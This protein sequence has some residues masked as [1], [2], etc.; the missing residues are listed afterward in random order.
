MQNRI[1]LVS[2]ESDF[3][4]YIS[5]K[6]DLR[7]NDELYH[8]AYED[9]PEKL[10]LLSSSVL[11]L[12]SQNSEQK[13]LEL[14]KILKST[15]VIV[16]SF[17]EDVDFRAEC[18][19]QG[20]LG[21]ITLVTQENEFNSIIISAL[22]SLSFLKKTENYRE[23]LVEKNVLAQNNEVYYDYKNIIEKELEKIKSGASSAILAAI[24]PNDK[25]KFLLNSNQIETFV[26]SNIRKSDIL[27]N[28]AANKYFLLLNDT[29]FE[30]AQKIWQN[31]Q[32]NI[33]EKLYAGFASS[34]NLKTC[35]QWINEALNKLHEAIN[36]DYVSP[37][38]NSS[39]VSNFKLFRQEF[40]KRLEKII[41][42]VFY[43]IEQ[44]YSEKLFGIS[45]VHSVTDGFGELITKS[46]LLCGEFKITAPGLSKINIDITFRS[47][48]ENNDIQSYPQSKRITIEPEE[49][50]PSLLEDLLEQFI[51]EFKD[52]VENEHIKRK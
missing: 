11:I 47:N 8:F 35:S 49:L 1:V 46:K 15:P 16:F 33:P 5:P 40:N 50:E 13:T 34:T 23:I 43:H 27:M 14:L 20:A 44:K 6:L 45:V 29:N 17:N 18:Y 4:E 51:L 37:L 7:K 9:V 38:S 52:E 32:Q 24:S 48:S 36:R 30:D 3:F 28:Y 42:P 10:D 41:L 39:S 25:T 26:L 12:N 21:Y 19:K 22:R 31:I 2:D